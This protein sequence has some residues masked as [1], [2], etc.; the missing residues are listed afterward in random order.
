VFSSGKGIFD[1]GFKCSLKKAS[2]LIRLASVPVTP[3]D[4]IKQKKNKGSRIDSK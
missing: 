4:Q 2:N 1:L 3:I